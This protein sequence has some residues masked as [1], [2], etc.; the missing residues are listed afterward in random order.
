MTFEVKEF[1]Q[2]KLKLPQQGEQRI[3]INTLTPNF[4]LNGKI[5]HKHTKNKFC[6]KL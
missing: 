3:Y 4:H 2:E 5:V 1:P 6:A